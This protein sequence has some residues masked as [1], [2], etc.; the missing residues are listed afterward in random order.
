VG[1]T[2]QLIVGGKASASAHRQAAYGTMRV[3]PIWSAKHDIQ[4][5]LN[6]RNLIP[7]PR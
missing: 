4:R 7:R 1:P 2:Q 3:I 6:V 5:A